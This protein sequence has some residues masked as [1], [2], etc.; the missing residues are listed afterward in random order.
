[1]ESHP[2]PAVNNSDF[3]LNLSVFDEALQSLSPGVCLL[4]PLLLDT[5]PSAAPHRLGV[6][7][8]STSIPVCL[9][10]GPG[11]VTWLR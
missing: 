2:T 10:L 9:A 3:G 1:M 7:P 8:P 11:Q 5:E 6:P 4:I